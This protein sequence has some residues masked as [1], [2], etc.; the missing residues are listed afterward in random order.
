M[1]KALSGELSC[2]CDRSCYGY[3]CVHH[4][5]VSILNILKLYRNVMSVSLNGVPNL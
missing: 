5:V 3:S 4:N 2:P 1:G